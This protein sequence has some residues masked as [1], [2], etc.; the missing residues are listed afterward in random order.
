MRE[1]GERLGV[2]PA[3]LERAN[4]GRRSIAIGDVVRMPDGREA[5]IV[6]MGQLPQLPSGLPSVP[7]GLPSGL[8]GGLP[9]GLPAGIPGASDLSS[10]PSVDPMVQQYQTQ[11]T[12]Q[13]NSLGTQGQAQLNQLTGG[14]VTGATVQ[15]GANALNALQASGYDPGSAADNA[16][17]VNAISAGLCLIPGGAIAAAGVQGLWFVGQRIACPVERL[18][19]NLLGGALSPACGGQPCAT[20]GNWTIASILAAS[21]LPPVSATGPGTFAGFVLPALAANT[22]A[23]LNCK[24]ALPPGAIVDAC[25]AL[26]NSQHG[27]PSVDLYVPPLND[28]V[29][30]LIPTWQNITGTTSFDRATGNADPNAYF[31]F[32]PS[33]WE[34]FSDLGAPPWPA[35]PAATA[36]HGW[37]TSAVTWGGP[38]LA[39]SAPRRVTVNVGPLLS[40]GPA[41]SIPSGPALPGLPAGMATPSAP[42]AAPA[43]LSTGAKVGIGVAA[44]A[45]VGTG[46][47]FLLGKPLGWEAVKAAFA[48]LEP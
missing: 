5:L 14:S 36:S 39:A 7:S 9:S 43:G 10:L 24:P 12:G 47:W 2:E 34:K 28:N 38:S 48:G 27:G 42:A 37:G 26:W 41:P 45:A 20:T 23:A 21:A 17:L 8:P 32:Q 30:P 4:P 18:F 16:N 25:A 40:L 3:A 13:T 46:V 6:R 15:N 44:T 31:A 19:H 22:M 35:P 1:L 29:P 33:G 11:L